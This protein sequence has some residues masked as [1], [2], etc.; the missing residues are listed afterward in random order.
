MG[1]TH[2]ER[3]LVVALSVVIAGCAEPASRIVAP[4]QSADVIANPASPP[5]QERTALTKI[6]QLVAQAMDNEPARQHLKRD[7]RAA[8]FRE[9]KLELGSYLKSKDG[10]ALL[11]RMAELGGG[12]G[13]VFATLAEIR[14]L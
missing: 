7:M 5:S 12:E 2:G 4:S 10:R 13:N 3:A 14:A 11:E 6:A 8:P 1:H 9:H